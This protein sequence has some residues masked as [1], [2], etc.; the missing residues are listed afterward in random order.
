MIDIETAT[1]NLIEGIRHSNRMTHA[2]VVIAAAA[3]L[4]NQLELALKKGMKPLSKEMYNRL[5][6]SSFGPLSSFANKIL[7][8]FAFGI[9]TKEIYDELEKIRHIRNEFAHSS[10]VL[11]F[12]SKEIAPKFSTLKKLHT[13]KKDPAEIFMTCVSVIDEFLEAYLERMGEPNREGKG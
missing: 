11:N 3:I 13:T 5:F 10:K 6:D 12:E 1:K 9:L 2:G 8:A 7:M 4:D